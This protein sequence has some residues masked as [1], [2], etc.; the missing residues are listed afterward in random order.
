MKKNGFTLVELIAVIV[1]I[2]I[3][4]MLAAP[5]IVDLMQRSKDGSFISEVD[6]LVSQAR[7]MYK[8]NNTRPDPEEDGS[9]KIYMSNL[10][11][12]VPTSD[13]YGYDY[14]MTNSYVSFEENCPA[15]S[16]CTLDT[17]VH[18]V[19]CKKDKVD[20]AGS[21][22]C[23]C[24]YKTLNNYDKEITKDDISGDCGS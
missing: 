3:I 7:Y 4:S 10:T 19:S 17:K 12:D 8:N 14:D 13:P 6:Q 16:M 9:V 5:N 11:G 22:V 1:I 15:D 23:H 2:S 24:I 20:A 18:I 21:N